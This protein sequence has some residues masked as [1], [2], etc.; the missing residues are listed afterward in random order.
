MRR[1]VIAVVA[2]AE[3]MGA[4]WA[5]VN[6]EGYHWWRVALLVL[7]VMTLAMLFLDTPELP[8][9]AAAAGAVAAV[10]AVVL[11]TQHFNDSYRGT[12]LWPDVLACVFFAGVASVELVLLRR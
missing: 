12:Y 3:W 1:A 5:S 11:T 10:V 9:W 6:G 4:A 2:L 8:R 7:M